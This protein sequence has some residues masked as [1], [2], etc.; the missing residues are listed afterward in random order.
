MIPQAMALGILPKDDDGRYHFTS[1]SFDAQ[2]LE[3][4][5]SL[6]L[7]YIIAPPRMK[8]YEEISTKIF[9]IYTKYVS[10]DDIH[11]YS[12][13]EVFLDVTGYLNR[14]RASTVVDFAEFPCLSL[15]FNVF[16]RTVS[17]LLLSFLKSMGLTLWITVVIVVV[18]SLLP[19]AL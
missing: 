8:L 12:I 2:A 6:E 19:Q 17:Y 4:D 1:S 11:V 9:S 7:S 10:P 14:Y 13:D 3:A 5:P 16:L 15:F 18:I